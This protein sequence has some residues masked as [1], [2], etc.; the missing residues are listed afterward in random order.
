MNSLHISPS[1]PK[2]PAFGHNLSQI[3]HR[4]TVTIPHL[5]QILTQNQTVWSWKG[6][7]Q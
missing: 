7:M 6:D 4:N 2:P 1:G 5:K 3:R